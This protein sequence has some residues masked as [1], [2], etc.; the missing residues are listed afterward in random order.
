MDKDDGPRPEVPDRF[1]Y[2][3]Y[4]SVVITTIVVVA[5]LWAFGQYFS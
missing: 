5:A 3:I 2:K 1:W 4:I